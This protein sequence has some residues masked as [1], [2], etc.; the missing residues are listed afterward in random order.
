MGSCDHNLDIL[1]AELLESAE[2]CEHMRGFRSEWHLA[3]APKAVA[4]PGENSRVLALWKNLPRPSAAD[5]RA[6]AR[7][8]RKS[9]REYYME[10]DLQKRWILGPGGR[11]GNCDECVDAEDMGWVDADEVYEGP[12]GPVFEPPMHPHCECEI[13]TKMRKHRVYV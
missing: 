6:K 4:A 13:E 2:V 7:A 3:E 11:E 1:T 5:S 10:E 9:G 8:A 12:M